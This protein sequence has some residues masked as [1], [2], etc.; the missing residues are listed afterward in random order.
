MRAGGV[1]LAVAVRR[2]AD[3]FVTAARRRA[4]GGWHVRALN[5]SLSARRGC[6]AVRSIHQM[7]GEGRCDTPIHTKEQVSSFSGSL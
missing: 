2:E 4:V 6:A 3:S 7:P 5:S 1:A